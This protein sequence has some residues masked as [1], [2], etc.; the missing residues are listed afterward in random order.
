M[1]A[2]LV[3]M[4]KHS[5]T[6]KA[7]T[8]IIC[9]IFAKEKKR[10]SYNF[11]WPK[12]PLNDPYKGRDL[13]KLYISVISHD[14]GGGAFCTIVWYSA[15]W[16]PPYTCILRI[17]FCGALT[18]TWSLKKSIISSF[19]S[20]LSAAT[21]NHKTVSSQ[22]IHMGK[23]KEYIPPLLFYQIWGFLQKSLPRRMLIPRVC[24]CISPV[25]YQ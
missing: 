8:Q 7:I 6:N 16:R 10:L 20:S 23:I 4:K 24:F 3:Q 5:F 14:C 9:Q 21:C 25:S 18:F 12:P 15:V 19:L 1:Q 11:I 13:L 17:F 22:T 2:N